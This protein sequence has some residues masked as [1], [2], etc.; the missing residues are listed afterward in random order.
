VQALVAHKLLFIQAKVIDILSAN[1]G[2]ERHPA[3]MA[4]SSAILAPFAK[5]WIHIYYVLSCIVLFAQ[6]LVPRRFSLFSV[7]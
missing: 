2:G 5:V 3:I 1:V 6:K 7:Y 4:Y